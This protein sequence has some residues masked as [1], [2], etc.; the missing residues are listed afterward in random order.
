MKPQSTIGGDRLPV[1]QLC[2]NCHRFPRK[3]PHQYCPRCYEYLKPIVC[4]WARAQNPIPGEDIPQ[5]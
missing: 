2:A 3:F 5:C 4:A 1:T